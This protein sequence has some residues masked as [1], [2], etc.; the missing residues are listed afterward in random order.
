MYSSDQEHGLPSPHLLVEIFIKRY[1]V[2][3][4]KGIKYGLLRL[5]QRSSNVAGILMQGIWKFCNKLL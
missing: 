4:L 1:Q 5:M 2:Q 3:I